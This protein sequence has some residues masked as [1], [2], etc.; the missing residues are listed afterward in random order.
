MRFQFLAMAAAAAYPFVFAYAASAASEATQIDGPHVHENLAVY[1][2]RG[3][4]ADGPVPLTLAEA[5]EQNRVKVIETGDVNELKVENTGD[6]AVFIQSGDI[7]KGGKQDRVITSSLMLQPKSGEVPLAAFCVEHGRW[8]PRGMESAS[9]FASAAEAVPSR[10]AKLA[11]KAPIATAS[12]GDRRGGSR[13]SE[14]WNSVS[15]M[16]KKLSLGV[17]ADVAAT[18]SASSLQLSLENKKLQEKRALYVAALQSKGSNDD[19][20]VGYAIAING[21]LNSADVY[22]SNG[23]FRKMWPKQLQAA[24]TEA[25]GEAAEKADAPPASDAVTAFLAAA[26]GGAVKEK[27]EHSSNRLEVRDSGQAV[28]FASSPSSGRV[29]HENYLAK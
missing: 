25:I 19:A 29:L 22:A 12:L 9:T 5:I 2:I 18:A 15:K 21:K 1:F 6:E 28:Y 20:I 10:E 8:A 27:S 26:K 3:K 13:Q 24:A 14:V 7:V 17:S 23:L 4:S 11:M 16:Q